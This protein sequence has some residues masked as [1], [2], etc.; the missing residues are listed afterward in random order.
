MT[1]SEGELVWKM[2]NEFYLEYGKLVAQTLAKVPKNIRDEMMDNIQEKSNVFS[3]C[4][5][6]YLNNE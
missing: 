5:E 4:F 2:G 3:S 6:K 1:E